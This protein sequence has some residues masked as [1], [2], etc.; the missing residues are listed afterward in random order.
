VSIAGGRAVGRA[1]A[2]ALVLAL[3][4]AGAAARS[5]G[6]RDPLRP[7][8]WGEEPASAPSFDASAWRLASTLIAE[9]RRVAIINGRSVREGGTVGGARVVGIEPGR[10]RLDY[11][12]RRFTIERRTPRVRS[13]EH[14]GERTE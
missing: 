13:G 4:A 3:F 10:A 11:Q 5:D 8:G 7:P 2:G 6:E 9:G 14:R 12:G 1:L